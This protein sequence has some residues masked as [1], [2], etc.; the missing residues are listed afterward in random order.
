[1]VCRAMQNKRH[2]R[3][4][5]ETCFTKLIG[6]VL[7]GT[8]TVPLYQCSKNCLADLGCVHAPMHIPRQSSLCT[9]CLFVV[10]YK[11]FICKYLNCTLKITKPTIL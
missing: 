6:M 9:Y 7:F 8:D 11:A 3:L 5:A 1:M 2:K 10:P 4:F